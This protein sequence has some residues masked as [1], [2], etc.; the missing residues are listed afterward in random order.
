MSEPGNRRQPLDVEEETFQTLLENAIDV[1]E[2]LDQTGVMLYVTPSAKDEW[3]YLPDELVGTNSLDLVHPEDRSAWEEILGR[4]RTSPGTV[5]TP[6]SIR[7]RH[8]NGYWR[9]MLRSV[10]ALGE[11][12]GKAAYVVNSHDIT[13]KQQTDAAL[14]ESENQFR[15]LAENSITGICLMQDGVFQYI[16]PKFTEIYGYNIQEMIGMPWEAIV[17]ED[18]RAFVL[19][20]IHKREG[21]E[22]DSVHYEYRAISKDKSIVH[23]EVYGSRAVYKGRP[24][25]LGTI[26][27]VTARK[28]LEQALSESERKFKSLAEKSM[29]G[30]YLIQDGI[31]TYANPRLAEM[32]GY[33]LHEFV[34]MMWKE[35]IHP[36]DLPLVA[37]NIHKREAGEIEAIHYE[38]RGLK[39]N[40]DIIYVDVYG[41]NIIHQGRLAAI[42]TQL[43]IT[44]RKKLEQALRKSEEQY[45]LLAENMHDMIWIA[46]PHSSQ[47][48]YASPSVERLLGYSREE[49]I[50]TPLEKLLPPASL[51]LAVENLTRMTEAVT[52]GRPIETPRL[53]L[54][55]IRKDGAIIWVEVAYSLILNDAGAVV[56]LQGVNRDITERKQA[57][58]E[59][60]RRTAELA[61]SNAELEQFAYIASH[62]L[63]EPLRMVAS[64]TELLAR[65]YKGRLDRD[66]DE[67]IAFA[68]DGANR[69]K[70]LINDLLSY[71]RVG[72]RGK[73][74]VPTDCR[75]VF[76]R[77][78]SNLTVTIQEHGATVKAGQLPTV[79]AD[80][81]QLT[82]VFQNL[83]ANAI[84]FH[85]PELP[86]V[87]VSAERHAEEWVFS[88][89]DNGIGIDPQFFERIFAIFQRLHGPNAYPGTGM[90]LAICRKI[91]ERHGGRIWVE[92]ERGRGSTFYFTTPTGGG[93]LE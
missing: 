84:K 11:S 33:E 89:Q 38:F 69:M 71:S 59:L 53:E 26:L 22:S 21:G 17:H 88:V 62:D 4:A 79:T 68:V 91:V 63:Q 32:Y 9:Q 8:K 2:A 18:D 60:A 19:E 16:N 41:T 29:V 86:L 51:T 78:L 49:L 92:S 12:S 77:A 43:D 80:P 10:K 6:I 15:A 25:I 20:N 66:A 61:R 65:R 31:I 81:V 36:L 67:F 85:G 54:Q 39:K 76:D 83:I 82:Q 45:R 5:M 90:G 7:I 50:D 14:L 34:G 87:D 55:H 42:G 28:Q 3:G 1:L 37:E 72:T 46:D 44:D 58:E 73:P 74:F 23:V 27:D 52:A 35:A 47:F 75:E 48:V 40:R 93:G 13:A 64:F 56:A 30:I 57:E 70:E 24:A